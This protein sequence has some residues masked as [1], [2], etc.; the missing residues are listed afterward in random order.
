MLEWETKMR[1]IGRYSPAGMR[2]RAGT[3]RPEVVLF[4]AFPAMAV[5]SMTPCFLPCH[6]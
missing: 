6:G 1:A 5:L 3:A 4:V 2:R